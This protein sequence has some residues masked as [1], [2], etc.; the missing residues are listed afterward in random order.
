MIRNILVLAVLAATCAANPW[1]KYQLAPGPDRKQLPTSWHVT[2]AGSTPPQPGNGTMHPQTC[3]TE[4]EWKVIGKS[5]AQMTLTCA[6]GAFTGVDF[7]S[8]GNPT[9]TCGSFKKGSCDASNTTAYIASLCVGKHTCTIPSD[10][11]VRNTL[12]PLDQALGD[13]C[14]EQAKTL[15]VQLACKAGPP[16][17]TPHP[18]PQALPIRLSHKGDSVMFDWG[19]ETG[20][21][22]TLNFGAT[23]DKLQSVSLAYSE[24]SYYWVGGDHSNGGSG[25]DGTISSGPITAH[26]S[27]TPAVAHMRGGFR[28]LNLVLETD[29][30]LEIDLP[31]VH[32]TATPNMPDPS[33]WK[34]HF[35]SSDDLLNRIWYGCGYT[36][37]MCR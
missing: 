15:S 1:D 10:P 30:W 23:S 19:K 26:G 28:Y 29:G 22:T 13:P 32:F 9:G 24:S 20:G 6:T 2:P 37:Q 21:F 7:A 18:T 8:F 33:A 17:P 34:N 12:S 27:H 16:T 3:G 4:G 36:T 35:Y 5:G 31:W 11:T 25:A 14:H